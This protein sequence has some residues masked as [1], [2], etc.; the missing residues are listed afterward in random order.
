MAVHHP[1]STP[2]GLETQLIQTLYRFLSRGVS[3]GH[4]SPPLRLSA[5]AIFFLCVL[6]GVLGA[7]FTA[8]LYQSWLRFFVAL[9]VL[10]TGALLATWITAWFLKISHKLAHSVQLPF[11]ALTSTLAIAHYPWWCTTGFIDR[12]PLITAC[13]FLC[14]MWLTRQWVIRDLKAPQPITTRWILVM[15]LTHAALWGGG[16]FG[17]SD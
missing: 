2:I 3:T 11:R 6:N 5:P 17:L 1:K 7:V 14:S 8:L 16:F 9:L 4:D 15:A 12:F 10:P 13:G